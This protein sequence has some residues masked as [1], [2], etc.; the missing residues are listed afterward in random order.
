MSFLTVTN[1][2]LTFK[3]QLVLRDVNFSVEADDIFVI[4]GETGSGK[5]TLQKALVG[6]HEPIEG[7]VCYGKYNLWEMPQQW[8]E[9][10]LLKLGVLYQ[11]GSFLDFLTVAQ[12]VALPLEIYSGLNGSDIEA[13]VHLKLSL[14]G[15]LAYRDCYPSQLNLQQA[16]RAGLAHAIALDPDVLFIDEPTLGLDPISAQEIEDILIQLRELVKMPII[17]VSSDVHSIFKL[18]TKAIFLDAE[19]KTSTVAGSPQEILEQ[20]LESKPRRFLQRYKEDYGK[21]D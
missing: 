19:R 4:M 14:V 9:Q 18:A 20:A 5:S 21:Q 11:Q 10:F 17:L 6:L 3:H 2:S 16:R 15:M 7:S 12:N 8:R 13:L 1:L